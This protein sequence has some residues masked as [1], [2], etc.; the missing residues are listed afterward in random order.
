[1]NTRDVTEENTHGYLYAMVL[2]PPNTTA[3]VAVS[4]QLEWVMTFSEP[5]QDDSAF[6][7]GTAFRPTSDAEIYVAALQ[8]RADGTTNAILCWANHVPVTYTGITEKESRN[9]YLFPAGITTSDE[10]K[11]AYYGV[12]F[13]STYLQEF[14]FNMFPTFAQAKTFQESNNTYDGWGLATDG[15]WNQ[16]TPCYLISPWTPTMKINEVLNT[17]NFCDH[18]QSSPLMVGKNSN[19][20]SKNLKTT[21]SESLVL[22]SQQPQRPIEEHFSTLTMS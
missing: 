5:Q 13:Q 10:T 8:I 9:I 11:K 21:S 16:A 12:P 14:V 18:C 19:N 15:P 17:T 2:A 6:D 20:H 7:L 1:M 22:V 4:L 3:P